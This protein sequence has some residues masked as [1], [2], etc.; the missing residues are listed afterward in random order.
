MID[1][2]EIIMIGGIIVALLIWGHQKIPELARAV[3][4]AKHELETASKGNSNDRDGPDIPKR[5]RLTDTERF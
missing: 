4:E 3:G 2:W 5:Q 1:P